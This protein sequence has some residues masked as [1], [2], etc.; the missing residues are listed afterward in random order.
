MPEKKVPRLVK[1]RV[2]LSAI[3]TFFWLGGSAQGLVQ[4]VGTDGTNARIVHQQ[5]ITGKE[6]HIGLLS[7]GNVRSTHEAFALAD[8]QSTVANYDFSGKGVAFTSHDTQVAGI[9]LSRGGANYAECRGVA[10]DARL[11]SARISNGS[12]SASAVERALYE[13]IVNQGC[14]VIVTGIQLSSQSA[15][16]DG[17]SVWAKLY[18]YYAEQYDVIFANAAGNSESAI[19]VFGDG[20]NGITT[21]GLALDE[22]GRWRITGSISNLGPTVDGRRKPELTAPVQRQ[23]VPGSASDTAWNAVGKPAGETSYAA[24][25]TA[26]AAALLMEYAAQTETPDDDRSLTIK[27]ALIHTA[28]PNLLG[29]ARRLTQPEEIVWHPH[30]GYGKLNVSRALNLLKADRARPGTTL[31]APAGWAYEALDTQE[32]ATYRITANKGQ[33]L[34]ITVVWH[35][36][37]T[38]TG[39]LFFAEEVPRLNLLLEVRTSKGKLLFSESDSDDNVRK[40]VLTLP[41]DE[42]YAVIVRNLTPLSGRNYVFAFELVDAAPLTE[43]SPQ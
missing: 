18:D 26:G 43:Y 12:I 10:P 13:L 31:V 41:E 24:P 38:R 29:R 5:G 23:M 16:P 20:F 6:I 28:D 3:S 39:T 32:R 27:A 15:R 11:H 7:S 25:H 17:S 22:H 30:R 4:S 37:L 36:K 9:I 2:F 35:R 19:T 8:D 34:S 14:R 21:G 40:A 33:R 42:T 1:W